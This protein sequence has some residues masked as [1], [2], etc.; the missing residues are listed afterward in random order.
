ML[1][2]KLIKKYE[3]YIGK[4]FGC[5]HVDS[6]DLSQSHKNRLYFNCTCTICNRKLKIRNDGL[7][8]LKNNEK[9]VGCK[10]CMGIWRKQNFEN[11][12]KNLPPKDIRNKFTHFRA[13]AKVRNIPFLLTKEEVN[14]LCESKCFYCG[15]ERCLG[16]DR[17]DNSKPYIIE[18]CVPCCGSCNQMKMDF[19]FNFFLNHVKQIY[20]HIKNS[21]IESSTTISKESTS[22][23]KVDGRGAHLQ[24]TN[25]GEDIVLS[26]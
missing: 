3:E 5:I 7:T 17:K 12:Y 4:D 21:N 16:I 9:R 11:K 19:E 13:N 2:E 15:K 22:K 1:S 8:N 23:V 25:Q 26:A 24:Y 18:N 14:T 6:I 20:Q 10:K